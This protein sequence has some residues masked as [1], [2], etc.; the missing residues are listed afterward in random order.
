MAVMQVRRWGGVLEHPASSTLFR[1]C[2]LPL[3]GE[4]ADEFGGWSLAC[5]QVAW[6]HRADKHTW[7]YLVGVDPS[8]VQVRT[9]GVATHCVTTARRGGPLLKMDRRESDRT[10]SSF[11]E[12][13]VDIARRAT[14]PLGP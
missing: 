1:A 5:H 4:P 6:G 8:D 3:P 9:G 12:F 13:L 7:L 11:A 2:G 14:I 10:P